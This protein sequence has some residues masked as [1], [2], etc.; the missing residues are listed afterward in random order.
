MSFFSSLSNFVSSVVSTVDDVLKPVTNALPDPLRVVSQTVGNT[1]GSDVERILEAGADAG[2]T[3]RDHPV[4]AAAIA[5]GGYQGI[6]AMGATEATGE[7]IASGVSQGSVTATELGTLGTA[8]AS[9][10]GLSGI[11]LGGAGASPATWTNPA[12]PSIASAASSGW[13]TG[14]IA[15]TATAGLNLASSSLKLAALGSSM[16][17]NQATSSGLTGALAA[18]P[19]QTPSGLITTTPQGPITAGPVATSTG[20][21]TQTMMVIAAAAVGIFYL[22]K[23]G[24]LKG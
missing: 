6:G 16:N 17:A 24:N 21:D 18:S 23:S 22:V 13:T 19:I 14:Q 5:Y 9:T 4:E 2:Q 20:M 15:S 7:V 10:A 8:E 1:F 11:D 12:A 3:I